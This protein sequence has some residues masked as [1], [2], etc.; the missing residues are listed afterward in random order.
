MN[1]WGSCSNA[2]FDSLGLLHSLRFSFFN[3]LPGETAGP[4]TKFEYLGPQWPIPEMV[5]EVK[6]IGYAPPRN[7]GFLDVKDS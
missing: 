5:C 7:K 4:W 6:S 2:D 1:H 3:K